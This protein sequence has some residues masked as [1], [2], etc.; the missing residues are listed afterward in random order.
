MNLGREPRCP[1]SCAG[2]L[3][4]GA[5]WSIFD[6]RSTRTTILA[7]S[8]RSGGR[9]R[10]G[11]Q[12]ARRPYRAPDAHRVVRR[13][14]LAGLVPALERPDGPRRRRATAATREMPDM[15]ASR[16]TSPAVESMPEIPCEQHAV[17]YDGRLIG[18]GPTRKMGEAYRAFGIKCPN[19]VRLPV[20]G[21]GSAGGS[22]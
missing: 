10:R 11:I 19:T 4:V 6:P 17:E 2:I 21:S 3:G 9:G 5:L 22:G 12:E 13:R 15:L 20:M 7:T 18:S 16:R 8:K 14:A 1:C